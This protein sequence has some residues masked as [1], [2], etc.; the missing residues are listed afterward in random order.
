MLSKIDKFH[1]LN[2]LAGLPPEKYLSEI[3]TESQLKHFKELQQEFYLLSNSLK[4]YFSGEYDETFDTL[5][6]NNKELYFLWRDIY[7]KLYG[8]LQSSWKILEETAKSYQIDIPANT[9]GEC[10]M[11]I[12]EN[13]CKMMWNLCRYNTDFSPSRNF[14]EISGNNK[15]KQKGDE[16][17]LSKNY[18]KYLKETKYCED[19]D[20][21]KTFVLAV[22]KKEVTKSMPEYKYL[23]EFNQT[24]SDLERLILKMQ[25]PNKRLKS[26]QWKEGNK[27]VN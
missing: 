23:K 7:L 8:I 12:I 14:K 20:N 21:L 27:F 10:L 24:I 9:P 15:L 22:V 18:L 17:Q 25:H 2:L 5:P 6:K 1:L 13:D 26:Y 11:R 19:L 4:K 3:N 16:N